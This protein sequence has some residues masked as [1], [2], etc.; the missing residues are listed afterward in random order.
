MNGLRQAAARKPGVLAT[1][2]AVGASFFGVRG[3][4]AHA[5][6]VSRLNPV[7]V[8][9]VGVALAA[10]FVGVLVLAARVAAG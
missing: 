9:V 7:V 6:D 1:V 2:K 3:G 10:V 8:I 4:R 5:H